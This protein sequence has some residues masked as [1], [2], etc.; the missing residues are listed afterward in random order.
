MSLTKKEQ[1]EFDELDKAL[2]GKFTITQ[3]DRHAE[4]LIKMGEIDE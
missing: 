3:V 1:K 2:D 4:L